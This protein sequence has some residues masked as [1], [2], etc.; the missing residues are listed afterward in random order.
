MSLRVVPCRTKVKTVIGGISA[1]ITGICIREDSLSYEISY[2]HN[3]EAK[4]AW[5]RPYEFEVDRSSPKKAGLVNYD[6]SDPSDGIILLLPGSTT[7]QCP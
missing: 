6:A 3:G 7:T 1:I 5:V 2:F 4:N